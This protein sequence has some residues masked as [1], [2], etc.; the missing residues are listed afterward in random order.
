MVADFKSIQY[1]LVE[2]ALNNCPL[3]NSQQPHIDP[4]NADLLNAS[5]LLFP[6]TYLISIT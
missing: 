6:A 5:Q 4:R 2:L 1:F 3:P